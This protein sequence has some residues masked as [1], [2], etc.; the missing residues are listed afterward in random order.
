MDWGKQYEKL[1]PSFFIGR[2]LKG[3]KIRPGLKENWWNFKKYIN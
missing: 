1:R 3:Y 2:P